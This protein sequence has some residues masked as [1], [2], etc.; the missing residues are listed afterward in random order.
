MFEL[1]FVRNPWVAAA[2]LAAYI[3]HS[4]VWGICVGS[5]RQRLVPEGLRGRVN[6]S[7]RVL[8]LIGLTVGAALGGVLA[9]SLSLSASFL[10]SGAL[11]LGCGAIARW[12]FRSDRQSRSGSATALETVR[13]GWASQLGARAGEPLAGQSDRV[14]SE[15]LVGVKPAPGTVPQRSI[16]TLL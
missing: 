5:L 3:L 9:S 15:C 16:I 13:N 6:A 10:V 2:L 1:A 7:S 11:F 12:L 14:P 4:V 8:G